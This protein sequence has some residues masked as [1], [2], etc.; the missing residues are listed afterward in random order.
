MATH[1]GIQ[2]H[3]FARF[4]DTGS[5]PVLSQRG[6]AAPKSVSTTFVLSVSAVFKTT[7]ARVTQV[8]FI[9]R[10]E[11]RGMSCLSG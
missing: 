9:V 1:D 6:C 10:G 3:I 8:L 2:T 5:Y 7:W 11:G 4:W